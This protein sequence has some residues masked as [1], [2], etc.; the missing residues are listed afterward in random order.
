[1]AQA[2]RCTVIAEVAQAHDGSLGL[3]HSFIDSAAHAGADGIKFQT[4]IAAAESTPAEPWRVRFSKQD[5]TRYE[6]WKRMEF[7]EE[8]WRDLRQHAL[9]RGLMFLSSPFSLEAVDLLE[10][11]GVH[12]WKVAS[13]EV[14]NTQLLDAMVATGTQIYLSSGMSRLA[15]LDHAVD[16]VKRAGVPLVVMQCTSTY[17]SPPEKIGLNLIPLLAE[18]YRVPVGLSD[19]SGTIYPGLA[20][21]TLRIGVLEVH[22]TLSREMYGPDVNSSITPGEFRQ[23]VK[24]VRFIEA[25]RDHPVD[26]DAMAQ[27]LAPLREIFTRSIV[28]RIRLAAGT[29]LR[30]ELLALKKPGTG[31]T[32]D[33]LPGVVGRRLRRPIEADAPLQLDDLEPE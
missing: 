3:A 5:E 1:M 33:Q 23:L 16:R 17:P 29:E 19:H 27:D 22:L 6:Y 21:A 10:R 30:E 32:A 2:S 11:V 14:T 12:A 15:E 31:L 25:M 13:G 7:S 20:A 9:D 24:G 26:K 8:Q 18:R 28:A 4:H